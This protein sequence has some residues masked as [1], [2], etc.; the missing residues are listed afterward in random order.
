MS[1]CFWPRSKFDLFF[2]GGG[3]LWTLQKKGGQNCDFSIATNQEPQMEISFDAKRLS[4]WAI[5]HIFFG[6]KKHLGWLK[7]DPSA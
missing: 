3:Q 7:V 4:D 2:V 6:G 1:I 5:Y